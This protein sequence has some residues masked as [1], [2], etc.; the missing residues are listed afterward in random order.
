MSYDL[1][2][3]ERPRPANN[4]AALE[5]HIELMDRSEALAE[6]EEPSPAIAAHI[7]GLLERWPDIT[8]EASKDSPWSDGPLINNATG[9]LFYFGMIFDTADEAPSLPRSLLGSTSLSASIP[10]KLVCAPLRKP[11]V[12]PAVCSPRSYSSARSPKRPS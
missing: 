1:A 7:Q 9:G 4:Q 10:R 6:P 2:V 11:T 3:W 12:R 8:E 5:T